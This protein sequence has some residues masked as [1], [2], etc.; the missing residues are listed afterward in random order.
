MVAITGV[1]TIISTVWYL[2]SSGSSKSSGQTDSRHTKFNSG[3]KL[4]REVNI[5][6]FKIGE[7]G[8]L[9]LHRWHNI[10]LHLED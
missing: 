2:P 3:M 10:E 5:K 4:L 9:I 7:N 8:T 1:W 6:C